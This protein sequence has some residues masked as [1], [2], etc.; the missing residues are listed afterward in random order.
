[1]ERYS[2]KK[3]TNLLYI[4]NNHPQIKY[5]KATHMKVASV[6]GVLGEK[7][8]LDSTFNSLVN[9]QG[10]PAIHYSFYKNRVYKNTDFS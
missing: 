6:A 10:K 1:M 9:D 7:V 3:K 8:M 2:K 5:R 4:K